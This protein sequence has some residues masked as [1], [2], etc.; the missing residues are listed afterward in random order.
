MEIRHSDNRFYIFE[1][2]TQKEI[3]EIVYSKVSNGVI[4]I[5]HTRVD[6]TYQGHGL[7]GKLLNALLD[8]A[9]LNNLKIVPVCEYAKA[10]FK[11]RPEIRFL[12]ADNYQQLLEQLD[13]GEA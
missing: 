5:D 11:K 4:S 10:A 7:A 13:K 6:E 8:Y 1:A 2:D 12:L 3:G 9:D